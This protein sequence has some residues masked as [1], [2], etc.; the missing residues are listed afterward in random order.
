MTL[1]LIGKDRPFGGKT[2]DKLVPGKLY[3]II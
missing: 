1:V 2:K 3:N